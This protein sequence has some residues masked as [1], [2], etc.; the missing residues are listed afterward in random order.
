V[1]QQVNLYQP[2]FRHQRRV[3]SAAA[4]VQSLVLAAVGLL[5]IFGY[6]EW[7]V[8]QLAAEVHAIERDRDA[9]AAQLVQLQRDVPQ[10]Q[11]SKVLAAEVARLQRAL[12]QRRGLADTLSSSAGSGRGFSGLLSGLSRGHVEGTWITGV[13]L[14]RADGDLEL[15]GSARTP[16]LVPRLV[17]KLSAEDEFSGRRFAALAIERPVAAPERVDFLLRTRTGEAQ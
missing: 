5:A 4:M 3:F 17:Q 14:A 12:A 9:A 16:E 11:P 8:R 2:M 6:G 15:R 10:R 7:Q 13:R 1:K